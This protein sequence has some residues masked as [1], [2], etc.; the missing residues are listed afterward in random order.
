MQRILKGELMRNRRKQSLKITALG[1]F[2]I[3]VCFLSY[4]SAMMIGMSTR[5][6]TLESELVIKGE[7]IDIVSQ[8]TEDRKAIF[9]IATIQVEEVVTGEYSKSTIE[10]SY[11]GGIVDGIGMKVSDTP[12]FNQG[13]TVILFL[14]PD[15][16]LRKAQAYTVY[17][18]A[19]GKYLI[20]Q[21]NVARKR[22]FSIADNSEAIDNDLSADELINKIRA[23]KNE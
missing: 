23:Y 1:L 10:V 20:D 7:V 9:S 14:T 13:E 8:W 11:D 22:G 5:K 19:Q 18:R 2:F 4:S 17:G 6:L 21:N 3:L 12:S 16:K 15:L